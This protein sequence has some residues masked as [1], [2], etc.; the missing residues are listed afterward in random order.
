M[1]AYNLRQRTKTSSIA[2][3]SCQIGRTQCCFISKKKMRTKRGSSHRLRAKPL[4]ISS[5]KLVL[6]LLLLLSYTVWHNLF[7][8]NNN[9]ITKSPRRAST[10]IAP[11]PSGR[12]L[13]SPRRSAAAAPGR[14]A[15]VYFP[16]VCHTNT[17]TQAHILVRVHI[18]TYTPPA[19][20]TCHHTHTH[21]K[22]YKYFQPLPRAPHFSEDF[23]TTQ[24]K[25]RARNCVTIE[26]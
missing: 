5:L 11:Q 6:L 9:Q 8:V 2:G 15:L 26:Y 14:V 3:A 20:Q 7:F 1:C 17:H 4:P 24:P 13:I 23:L 12:K 25:P 21:T 19:R 22:A 10:E 18:L 16:S